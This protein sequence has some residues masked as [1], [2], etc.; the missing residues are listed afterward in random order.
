[1]LALVVDSSCAITRD[2]ARR[3]G[4]E[5]IPMTYTADGRVCEET[6]MGENGDVAALLAA[7]RITGTEG[8]SAASFAAVFRRLSARGDDVVCITISSRLSSTYRHA[9]EAA[10]IVRGELG[11][12][13]DRSPIDGLP[14]IAVIDSQTGVGGTEFIVRHARRLADEGCSFDEL[15]CGLEAYR[16]RQGTCFSVPDTDSLRASGRLAMVPMSVSTVLNRFPILTMCDGAVAHV[17]TARG[18]AALA[19]A[20]V[21][22]VPAE[23]HHVVITH[24]GSRGP[25]TAE[26]LRA[27]KAA[28]PDAQIRVKEGGPILSYV[29]GPGAVSITWDEDEPAEEAKADEG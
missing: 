5:M 23:T 1:M 18:N 8:V 20:M 16:S 6:F 13:T 25:A 9:C 14:R 3:L 19:R 11:R 17:G 21:E 15:I 4:C 2:E 7:G 28:L 27:A 24:Y 22:R 12:N 10:D 29:L 26:L